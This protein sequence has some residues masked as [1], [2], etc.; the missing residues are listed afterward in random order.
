M[1]APDNLNRSDPIWM[2][3]SFSGGRIDGGCPEE[4][5][6]PLCR[7]EVCDEVVG[8]TDGLGVEAEDWRV[9]RLPAD[10]PGSALE[11]AGR[12]E[13]V[14]PSSGDV[15]PTPDIRSK[16]T[17]RLFATADSG[18][19]PGPGNTLT[20]LSPEDSVGVVATELVF[21]FR[22]DRGSRGGMKAVT[23]PLP[24]VAVATS[25][26]LLVGGGG[27]FGVVEGTIENLEMEG[28]SNWSKV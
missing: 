19:G 22:A 11:P 23:E 17:K 13:E 26:A 2:G 7:V 12:S 10:T 28:A 5:R 14:D 3:K 15:G 21:R 1:E 16:V 18:P 8:S 27:F 25:A 4:V 24:L 9:L 6:V 20:F